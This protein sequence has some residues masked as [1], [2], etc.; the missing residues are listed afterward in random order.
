MRTAEKQGD[1]ELGGESCFGRWAW[2]GLL[3]R[4]CDPD[5]MDKTEPVADKH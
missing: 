1:E 4:R 2:E 5:I 3:G